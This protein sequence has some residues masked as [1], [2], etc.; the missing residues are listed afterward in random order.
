MPIEPYRVTK[1]KCEKIF[2]FQSLDTL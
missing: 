2:K 1:G